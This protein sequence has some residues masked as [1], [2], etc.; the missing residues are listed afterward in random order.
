MKKQ[1]IVFFI[2]I[3]SEWRWKEWNIFKI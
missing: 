1:M 3:S 2:Y